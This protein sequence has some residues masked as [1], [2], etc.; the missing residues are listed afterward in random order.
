MSAL[1]DYRSTVLL[2]EVPDNR[3]RDVL[4]ELLDRLDLE[5]IEEATPDYVAYELRKRLTP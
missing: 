1:S 2:M 3:L 5:I 4:K